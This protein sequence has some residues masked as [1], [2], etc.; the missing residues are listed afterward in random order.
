MSMVTA[1]TVRTAVD[2]PAKTY[3]GR[4]AWTLD[5]LIAAGEKGCT[6][7]EQPAPRWSHYVHMLRKSGIEVETI[8]ER[9]GGPFSGAHG[10]YV[11]RT[12]LQVIEKKVA[13]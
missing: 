5:N 13:A 11:L 1:I 4:V 6:P 3:R 9:H 10:R 7:I 2:A 12:P 8:D